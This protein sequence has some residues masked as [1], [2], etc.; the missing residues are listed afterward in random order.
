MA[1]QKRMADPAERMMR[2]AFL[3]FLAGV[4]GLAIAAIA[5]DQLLPCTYS[6]S[7]VMEVV[8]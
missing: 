4:A 8:K 3:C 5:I 7:V 6:S 1:D 2:D